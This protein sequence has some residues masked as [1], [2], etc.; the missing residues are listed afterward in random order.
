MPFVGAVVVLPQ[1][2]VLSRSCPTQAG[3]ALSMG[4]P[5]LICLWKGCQVQ[6]LQVYDWALYCSASV[7]LFQ[8]VSIPFAYDC[9]CFLHLALRA[10]SSR[11]SVFCVN[12]F[13]DFLWFGFL[14]DFF[15]SISFLI[16]LVS[17]FPFLF[18]FCIFFA[19]G[20][21]FL[22]CFF[23]LV[24]LSPGNQGISSVAFSSDAWQQ[25][26]ICV[27]K[28][29]S[30]RAGCPFVSRST[31]SCVGSRAVRGSPPQS[32]L[33]LLLGARSAWSSAGGDCMECRQAR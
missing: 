24:F 6:G 7:K 5:Y 26:N 18:S 30:G 12:L 11:M 32:S 28:G 8:F 3:T 21:V 25:V 31:D 27:A 2:Q 15:D 22:L 33:S 10:N 19:L 9:P 1:K 29:G 23:F 14:L 16:S 20:I 13:L 17:V 4:H